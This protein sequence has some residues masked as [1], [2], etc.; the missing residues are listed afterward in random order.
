MKILLVLLLIFQIQDL[1]TARTQK[2]VAQ[3]TTL[4]E[5][6]KSE[7]QN[8]RLYNELGVVEYYLGKTQEA[9]TSWRRAIELEATYGDARANLAY[10]Y[11]Q[12][13]REALG[14]D[15]LRSAIQVDPNSFLANY[16][17]GIFYYRRNQ[18]TRA[19]IYLK[20]AIELNPE[21]LEVRL[22]L[23]KLYRAQKNAQAAESELDKL[24]EIAPD[25]AAVRYGRAV[26]YGETGRYR[27]AI[28]E[29]EN[30]L[31]I[32]PQL[33]SVHFEIAVAA[34][35]EKDWLRVID[36]LSRFHSYDSTARS[37]YLMGYAYGQLRRY[38]EAVAEYENAV[39]L[40]PDFFEAHFE[41]SRLYIDKADVAQAERHLKL[42][43]KL[44]E[45]VEVKYL[46]GYCYELTGRYS[47]AE[48]LYKELLTS[49]PDRYE[50]YHGLGSLA[51]RSGEAEAAV[52]YLTRAQELGGQTADIYYLLGRARL[53]AGN[54]SVAL[55]D[56]DRAV[57]LEPNRADIRYQ[58]AQALKRLKREREAEQELKFV[59]ELNRRFR[60][61]MSAG[62]QR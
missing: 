41:L 52:K 22:E 45:Q 1:K 26:H 33:T 18:P 42:A 35:A 53:R 27:E 46:L 14:E 9:E 43:L 50:G 60:T 58:R 15:L 44:R 12:T 21:H 54:Y 57:Q 20:R 39:A 56:F 62:G 16:Y 23:A 30:V 55:E 8:A 47:E 36:S 25:S 3:E 6:L 40:K 17:S 19:E 59:E 24:L 13:G 31:L 7:P 38:E 11:F 4:L 37:H 51:V 61:G 10:Y 2:L 5:R 34:A 48:V 28:R 49:A 29:F 32:D